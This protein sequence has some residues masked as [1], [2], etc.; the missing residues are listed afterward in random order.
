[1]YKAS[2]LT[3]AM[4]L[5]GCTTLGNPHPESDVSAALKQHDYTRAAAIIEQTKPGHPEYP[6]LQEQYPGIRQASKAYRQHIILQAQ[7]LGRNQQWDDAFTLLNENR[8]KVLNPAAIDELSTALSSQEE[9][10]LNQLLAERRQAQAVAMLAHDRLEQQ[11]ADFHAPHAKQ[12]RQDLAEERQQLIQDLTTLGEYFGEREQ[13]MLARDL[14]RSAHQLAPQAEPSPVLAQAQQVLNNEEQRARAKR[15]LA[16]QTQ[17]EQLMSRYQ[18]NGQLQ[19][20]LAARAFLNRHPGNP[21]LASHRKRLEQWCRRRFA[22]EMNTGEALY[23]RGQYREAYRIWK[24]VAPL[25]P[26]NEELN[27]KLERSQRVLSNLRSLQQS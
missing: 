9:R 2:S 16:L 1:M 27:K 6:V 12:E 14:L 18:R 23:A 22:E 26:D 11:L 25:Y 5:A 10:Q 24:Q 17:A 19:S 3:L 7:E 21:A 15:N 20:L 4:V 8:D 13:W